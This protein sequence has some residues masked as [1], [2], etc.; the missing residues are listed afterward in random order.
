[1]NKVLLVGNLTKDPELTTT[2]NGISVCRFSIAVSRRY[3]G[4]S[5]ER[6]T[7]FINIVVW[8]GQAE[9]CHKYLKKGSKCGIVGTLQTRSYDAQDGSKRYVTEVVADEVEFISTNRNQDGTSRED[10][11]AEDVTEL[12][13]IDDDSLPF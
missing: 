6:E 12:K 4:A 10:A 11:P 1:M 5:G 7:D 13:P 2:T 9:N 8:R 3:V